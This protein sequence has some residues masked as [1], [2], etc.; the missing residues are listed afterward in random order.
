MLHVACE[1]GSTLAVWLL[2]Y[3]DNFDAFMK[4][5]NSAGLTPIEVIVL[6]VALLHVFYSIG[7]ETQW[8]STSCQNDDSRE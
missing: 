3:L 1:V 2:L 5:K 6:F 4:V 8:I 7:G